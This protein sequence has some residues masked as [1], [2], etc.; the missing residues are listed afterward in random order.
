[1]RNQTQETPQISFHSLPMLVVPIYVSPIFLPNSLDANKY[2]QGYSD[3]MYSIF[4]CD[5]KIGRT[6]LA[7]TLP[8]FSAQSFQ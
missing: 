3:D 8:K 7:H 5:Q 6:A 2:C 4:K 1:M